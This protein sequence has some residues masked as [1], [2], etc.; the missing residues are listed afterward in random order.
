MFKMFEGS[1][2]GGDELLVIPEQGIAV[3]SDGY[4]YG[5]WLYVYTVT[6][7]DVDKLKL[8]NYSNEAVDY[9]KANCQQVELTISR[10]KLR[11]PQGDSML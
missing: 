1:A 3:I 6:P 10:P 4:D 9:M 8:C 11:C 5:S 7:N 2:E